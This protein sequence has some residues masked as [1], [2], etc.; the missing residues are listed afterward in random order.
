MSTDVIKL[1]HL[2]ELAV[3]DK[4]GRSLGH[5]HDVRVHRAGEDYV[6]D[7]LIIGRRGLFVRLGWRRARDPASVSP[8]DILSW[9]DVLAIEDDRLIVRNAR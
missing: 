3:Q 4:S 6:V 2:L 8:R 5:V 1:S 7:G 9:G